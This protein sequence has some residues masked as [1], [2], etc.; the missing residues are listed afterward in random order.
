MSD[1]TT[2]GTVMVKDIGPG[3]KPWPVP[4]ALIDVGGT[5]YFVND[6]G[7]HGCE[8]WKSDGTE[9]GTV[10]VKDILPGPRGS[11]P[12]SLINV[13]GSLYFEIANKTD[14]GELWKSDG[15]SD[16]TV[17]VETAP[18][19]IFAAVGNTLYLSVSEPLQRPQLWKLMDPSGRTSWVKT[20]PSRH[21][22]LMAPWPDVNVVDGTL[23]FNVGSSS[24]LWKTDG[25]TAGTVLVKNISPRGNGGCGY[26]NTWSAA[27]VGSTFYFV[28]FDLTHFYQVWKS[29]GTG[30]GTVIVKDI[31]QSIEQ[32]PYWLT[33]VGGTLYFVAHDR[34]FGGG[35]W[36]SDGTDSG[37]V[38]VRSEM[39]GGQV[40]PTWNLT[41]AGG[42]LFF[43]ASDPAHGSELWKSDG[44]E[45]GTV[46][47]KDIRTGWATSAASE[48][49]YVP[50][51]ID[52][53]STIDQGP[54]LQVERALFIDKRR[55]R[56][57]R[58]RFALAFERSAAQA[59][60]RWP[61]LGAGGCAGQSGQFRTCDAMASLRTR[62]ESFIR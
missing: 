41:D 11:T 40:A 26:S 51:S 44:T 20:F 57:E 43:T 12:D 30:I 5:L 46:M 59:T 39:F 31:D 42:T 9:T 58:L 23:F 61:P 22:C 48:F 32:F 24:S 25:T 4:Q 17:L 28:A 62:V 47:V 6:D 1:G 34:N 16:G 55:D 45:T 49:V 8:L 52:P 60:P 7:T 53:P 37:T 54:M 29:D 10:M 3:A 13:G 56:R 18:G 14:G 19:G 36:R 27:T 15:T 50:G 21:R 33:G 35:L 2:S 38:I